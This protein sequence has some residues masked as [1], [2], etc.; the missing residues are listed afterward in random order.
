MPKSLQKEKPETLSR[1]F[2]NPDQAYE[3]ALKF[4]TPTYV[5]SQ[6]ILEDQAGKALAFPNAYGLT[7]RCAMKANPNENLIRIPYK[8]GVKIDASSGYEALRAMSADI[9]PEDI[10][11]TSQI[12]PSNLKQ[13]VEIGVEYNACSLHQL[14]T[15]GKLFPNSDVSLRVN[16]GR[17]SGGTKR[18]NTGGP[19]SSFG[20]WHEDLYKA[21]AIAQQYGLNIKRVHTHIGSGSDPE[22]WKKVSKL[23]LDIVGKVLDAGHNVSILNLGGG[24][25]VGRMSYEKSTDLQDCGEPVARAFERFARKT[26][27]PLRLEIEPGTF[28]FANSGA[29]LARVEDI[30]P[31]PKYDFVITDSGM[32]EV[33]RPALYGAQHPIAILP[34]NPGK[35]KMLRQIVSGKCCE[36]GDILTPAPGDSEA[37]KPR[38]MKE[39]RIGDLAAIG[40]AGAYCAGMPTKNYNSYP[41]AAEVLIDLKGKPHL[42]R[43]RQT[44]DQIIENERRIV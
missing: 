13:L 43:R 17:G 36:S 27:V 32:T 20:I 39:A 19:S 3:V 40:G 33:T 38:L 31:T 25:K 9:D 29:V 42:I 8:K 41:E 2:S 35:R 1:V 4:G 21:L 24:Y 28:L 30:K 5:Y 11:L 15:Y 26:G 34:V 6:R 7:V 37:L 12:I 22:V 18:T 14:E 10:L 44:L 23:S 16:P